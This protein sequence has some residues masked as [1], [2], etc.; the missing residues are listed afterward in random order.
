MCIVRIEKP[1]LRRK[2][3]VPSTAL[4]DEQAERDLL[5]Y[6][7]LVSY[8]SAVLSDCSEDLFG[9]QLHRDIAAA[10]LR[11]MEHR[12]PIDY[13]EVLQ[14]LHHHGSN[15]STAYISSLTEGVVLARSIRRRIA[16]LQELS[17]RRR[18]AILAERLAARACDLADPVPAI[19]ADVLESVQ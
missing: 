18:L 15:A 1:T 4:V 14:E 6:M 10:I 2:L 13:L 17:Q 19:V 11:L 3:Q 12:I 9:T 16:Y 5:G 7:I 8:N